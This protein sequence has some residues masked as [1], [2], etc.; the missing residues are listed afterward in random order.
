MKISLIFIFSLIFNTFSETKIYYYDKCDSS[1]TS[2]IDAIK[3][4]GVTLTYSSTL[5]HIAKLNSIE[6]ENFYYVID[7]YPFKAHFDQEVNDYLLK[8]LKAG[9][10]ISYIDNYLPIEEIKKNFKNEDDFYGTKDALM[11]ICEYLL[12]NSYMKAPFIAA[13]LAIIDYTQKFG[14]LEYY[15]ENPISITEISLNELNNSNKYIY[16]LGCFEWEGE[17]AKKLVEL[18]LEESQGKDKIE[19]KQIILAEAKMIVNYL[20]TNDG[21]KYDYDYWNDIVEKKNDKYTE[22][23][24]YSAKIFAQAN[25]YTSCDCWCPKSGVIDKIYKIM[26]ESNHSEERKKTVELKERV[27]QLTKDLFGYEI[28][29]TGEMEGEIVAP[30]GKI[31]IKIFEKIKFEKKGYIKYIIENNELKKI[32]FNTNIDIIDNIISKI[33]DA[34][35]G[36]IQ[37]LSLNEINK[38]MEKSISNANIYV[39]YI[40]PFT[41]EYAVIFTSK[42]DGYSEGETGVIYTITYNKNKLLEEVLKNLWKENIFSDLFAKALDFLTDGYEKLLDFLRENADAF[43]LIN[44]LMIIISLG[45]AFVTGGATPLPI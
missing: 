15:K 30:Y 9:K 23:V 29:F 40:F 6:K 33:K 5:Y 4:V 22:S 19:M 16:K 41:L 44:I 14:K 31:S 25:I 42:L 36:K 1:Y 24:Y 18:Y 8:L 32:D 34:L 39:N 45:L 21:A 11:T 28:N 7:Y 26:T 12:E 17:D 13:L 37:L 3:S 27:F 43:S 20:L 10:L 38:K 2:F 35:N